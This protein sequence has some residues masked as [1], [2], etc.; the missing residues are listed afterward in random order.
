MPKNGTNVKKLI[1]WIKLNDFFA[2]WVFYNR[3][4]FVF[5]LLLRYLNAGSAKPGA[6]GNKTIKNFQ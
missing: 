5:G 6:R 3:H 4:K 1:F 2:F